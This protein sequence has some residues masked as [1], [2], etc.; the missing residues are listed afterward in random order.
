MGIWGPRDHFSL[1]G[2][3]EGRIFQPL[4]AKGDIKDETRMAELYWSRYPEIENNS[5]WGRN[6]QL[7][8]RGPWDHYRYRGR[9]ERKIW[10][11]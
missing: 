9:F 4:H 7:G 2:K 5:I 6:S 3:R 11:K 8:I 10:G 1:H